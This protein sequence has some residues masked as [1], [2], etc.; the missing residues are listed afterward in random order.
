[1]E[2]KKLLK[3]CATGS[4]T[5]QK[6]LFDKYSVQYFILCRRYMKTKE[7]A[8]EVMMNGFLQI[9]KAIKSF[10]YTNEQAA[11]SWQKRIMVNECL[12]ALRKR[13][14]FLVAIEEDYSEYISVDEEAIH[15]LSAE[16]IFNLITQLP[17]GYKIVFNLYVIEGYT[18]KEISKLLNIS[19]GTSKSQLSKAKRM[20]QHFYIKQNL[21]NEARSI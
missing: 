8:E 10:N 14:S 11:I 12:Q 9:F 21:S 17:A 2:L 18:H 6:Y 19:E 3:E 7:E 15:K 5:A 4:I 13:T 1:M 16:E 20:L